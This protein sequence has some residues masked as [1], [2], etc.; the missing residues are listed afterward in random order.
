M[1]TQHLTKILSRFKIGIQEITF[2]PL[3]V[4]YINDTFLVIKSN[5]PVYILQ[6]I[7]QNVFKSVEQL[8]QNIDNALTKLQA[9][10][11][12]KVKLLKTDSGELFCKQNDNYWRLMT[13]I[14]NSTTHNTTSNPKI[15]FEAGRI[16]GRFHSLLQQEFVE[17][18]KDTI[19]NFNNLPFRITEFNEALRN[20]SEEK[21]EYALDEINFAKKNIEKFDIFYNSNLPLRICHNDT[22]LNNI[23]FNNSNEA[24]CL[25]DLDT[26]MKGYFHYDFGDAIRT[27]VSQANEDEK[28]LTKIK[29]NLNL[30]QNFI[31]GLNSSGLILSKKEIEFLPISAALMP[32]MHG[33][34][35]LTDY[36]NGNVYY[37]ITYKNQN[38]NRCKSLFYFT[39]LAL[40]NQKAITTVIETKIK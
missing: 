33:L 22:K 3:T 32:F 10:D 18:F 36:L 2:E 17:D 7:N 9:N 6:R 21:K 25:I 23:L 12:S 13:F 15:A 30:F 34:R 26:I 35:A 27:I 16:I 14:T 4:G 39:D 20:T 8:I 24:L 11:Y 19:P 1:K 31:E 38:L 37:T 40:Q 5:R 28:D 29:F